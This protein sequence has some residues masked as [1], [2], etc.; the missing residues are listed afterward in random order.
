MTEGGAS[1]K[2]GHTK[3]E[4]GGEAVGRRVKLPRGAA[5][6]IVVYING[7]AQTEGTDYK[8]ADGTIVFAEPIMKEGKL[9]G[10]R[11]LSLFVGLVGTYRKH[12]VVDVEYR[13][14]GKTELGSDLEVLP[15]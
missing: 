15:D 14:E 1:G 4:K 12:E 9:S 10:A 6:P 5:P 7:V 8:I 13:L 11:K 2:R 3:T